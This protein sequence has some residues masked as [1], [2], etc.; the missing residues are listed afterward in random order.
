VDRYRAD[1]VYRPKLTARASPRS[2]P[3]VSP[4]PALG[5][6]LDLRPGSGEIV[7]GG[8]QAAVFHGDDH[9]ET[10]GGELTGHLTADAARCTGND[11]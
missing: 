3:V 4:S 7:D 2:W 6:T 9:A 8:H 10:V 11:G 5:F 1:G